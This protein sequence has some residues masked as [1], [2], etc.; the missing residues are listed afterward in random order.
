MAIDLGQDFVGSEALAQFADAWGQLS[1]PLLVTRGVV[2]EQ[3]LE[4]VVKALG[5]TR[6]EVFSDFTPCPQLSSIE[7]FKLASLSAHDAIIAL[8][9]GS[10]FDC[11]KALKYQWVQSLELEPKAQARAQSLPLFCVATTFGSGAEITPFAVIY[12]KKGKISLSAPYLAPAA[13]ILVPQLAL[14]VPKSQRAAAGVDCLCQAIESYWSRAATTESKADAL[15]CIKLCLMA[16]K[17]AVLS[18]DLTAHTLLARASVLSGK[19]IA[20]G[21]T[22]AAH[23]LS[24]YFTQHHNLAHGQAVAL[25][26]RSLFAR[27][28]AALRDRST[29]LH[30]L[31][32]SLAP[33]FKPWFEALLEQLGL[34]TSFAPLQLDEAEITKAVASVNLQRLANN[35]VTLDKA[36]LR[37][38]IN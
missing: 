2:K 24:Y 21:R 38:L 1:Y 11:A 18:D 28:V 33:D 25:I 20:V 13:C 3:Y 10:A 22:T 9:G 27:N 15:E 19:A 32:L 36:D 30:A 23:A 31:G 4:V 12:T 5:L 34:L 37:A 26:M 35:P 6:Y 14:S 7:R 8:G 16:L 29:L 17:P